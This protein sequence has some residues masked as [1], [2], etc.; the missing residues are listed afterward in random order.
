MRPSP[1]FPVIVGADDSPSSI[2]ALRLAAEESPFRG[3][4][5]GPPVRTGL[6]PRRFA[7]GHAASPAARVFA[8]VDFA[9]GEPLGKHCSGLAESRRAPGWPK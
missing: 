4:T 2:A 6:L 8:V 5:Y 9:P 1:T 7:R 3:R